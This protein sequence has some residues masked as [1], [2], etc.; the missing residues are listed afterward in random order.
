MTKMTRTAVKKEGE[1]NPPPPWEAVQEDW[2][3]AA[4][5]GYRQCGGGA[6]GNDGV[7]DNNDGPRGGGPSS[8]TM[9]TA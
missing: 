9:K 4:A 2:Q 6:L 7:E 5:N 1:W 3:G 8:V